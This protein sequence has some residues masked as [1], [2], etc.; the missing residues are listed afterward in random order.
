MTQI[1][2]G[3]FGRVMASVSHEL[4]NR[5]AIIQEHAGL[6][7]DYS[8]MAAQGRQIELERLGRLGQA[9]NEQVA[10]ADDILRNM[11]QLAHTIDEIFRPVDL[12][13]L[14]KLS[15]DLAKRPAN[16]H[17]IE[18]TFRPSEAPIMVTTSPFFLMKIYV[19]I[20][21]GNL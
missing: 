2:I 16:L 5:I 11:N 6:L 21:S 7:K 17:R 13:E 15:V 18:L 10:K 3:F 8:A 9:L 12:N 4:K 20:Y 19:D 14:V 1:G